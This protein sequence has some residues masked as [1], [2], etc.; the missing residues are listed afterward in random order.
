[1]KTLSVINCW[2][3]TR[4]FAVIC[5]NCTVIFT[6]NADTMLI[7]VT[8]PTLF[9]PIIHSPLEKREAQISPQ[10][11]P[12]AQTLRPLLN[13]KKYQQ[14]LTLLTNYTIK[15]NSD[16]SEVSP[17]LY[18]LKAQIQ[19]QLSLA[20]A[21]VESYLLAV[22]LMP[23][24][25]RAHQGLAI[26]YIT[27]KQNKKA[28][29]S[30]IRAISLGANNAQLYAQLAYINMQLNDPI[31]AINAYQQA[32]MLNPESK[33]LSR[34]LLFAFT[35]SKQL[36]AAVSLLDK[37]LIEQSLDIDLWLQRANLALAFKDNEKALSSI[38]VAIRLGDKTPQTFQLAAQL[39]VSHKNYARAVDLSKQLIEQKQLSTAN[40]NEL[41]NFLLKEKQ[42]QQAELLLSAIHAN[43]DKKA[44]QYSSND[45]AQLLYYQGVLAQSNNELD[46]AYQYYEQ[47]ITLDPTNGVALVAIAKLSVKQN[48]I[49]HAE[50]FYQRAERLKDVKLPAML[51][52]VQIYID[53]SNYAKALTLL[54][55]TYKAFP[56]QQSLENNI[57]TLASIVNNQTY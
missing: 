12:L 48:K 33:S 11:Y 23:D 8:E 56:Q 30:L 14:V 27:L 21:A 39:H 50:L 57:N 35:Q 32:L 34:G 26:A 37:L 16:K 10:E 38:E 40:F 4:L 46:L 3:I 22:E 36:L 44:P 6:T 29:K 9:L 24:L 42:W 25:V 19:M 15:K 51:G 53:Q 45:N 20:E 43:I 54:R 41:I 7:K 47:A 18:L 5:I 52:R 1:M 55:E 17:A 2:L 31:S 49:T 28:Q 13:D